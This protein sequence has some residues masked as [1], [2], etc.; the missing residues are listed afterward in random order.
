M[1]QKSL[2][3]SFISDNIRKLIRKMN[4]SI[5]RTNLSFKDVIAKEAEF[6]LKQF[7]FLS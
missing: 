1:T 6:F 2:E 3:L 5:Y 4:G 7:N